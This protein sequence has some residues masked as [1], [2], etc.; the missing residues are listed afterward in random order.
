MYKRIF[1]GRPHLNK[2]LL[3]LTC[4]LKFHR[5]ALLKSVVGVSR[6]LLRDL[7]H[8]TDKFYHGWEQANNDRCTL[9]LFLLLD[10]GGHWPHCWSGK[11]ECS[12]CWITHWQEMLS[13]IYYVI[14]WCYRHTNFCSHLALAQQK[15]ELHQWVIN[16]W[17]CLK[18]I[19]MVHSTMLSELLTESLV[20]RMIG[21]KWVI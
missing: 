12:D 3:Q 16:M 14:Y 1:N 4:R 10:V 19:F 9:P 13:D 5:R 2:G 15:L 21:E 6:S 17:V 20:G 8:D 11:I 7:F 18:P